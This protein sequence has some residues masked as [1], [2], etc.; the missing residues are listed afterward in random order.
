MDN[1]F[2]ANFTYE[3]EIES[4]DLDEDKVMGIDLVCK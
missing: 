1:F 4:L 2:K 3:A